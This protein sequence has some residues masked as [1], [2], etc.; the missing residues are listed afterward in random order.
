[1]THVC[2]KW[3]TTAMSEEATSCR[4]AYT[5]II[6]IKYSNACVKSEYLDVRV[7]VRVRVFL[8]R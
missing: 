3:R 5:P 2:R 4:L 6:M 8:C 7:R 1:M